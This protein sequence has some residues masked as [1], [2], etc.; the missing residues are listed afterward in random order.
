MYEINSLKED[1]RL[2]TKEK[3]D[4]DTLANDKNEELNKKIEGNE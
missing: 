2:L 3:K 4:I 1:N